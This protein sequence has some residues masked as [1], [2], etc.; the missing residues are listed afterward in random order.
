MGPEIF[1]GC[2][3]DLEVGFC[4]LLGGDS[5]DFIWFAFGFAHHV[6]VYIFACLLGI[7]GYIEGVSGSFGDGETVVKSDATGNGTESA[8]IC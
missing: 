1:H 5:L 8:G 2:F 3:G 6:G 7:T 4:F